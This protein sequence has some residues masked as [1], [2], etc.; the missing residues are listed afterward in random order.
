MPVRPSKLWLVLGI[1]LAM[2]PVWGFLGTLFGMMSSFQQVAASSAPPT[3]KGVAEGIAISQ[4]STFIG[5]AIAPVGAL[6]I[7][8]YVIRS[9]RSTNAMH[10][11]ENEELYSE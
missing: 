6:L 1:I 5:L 3:P 7:A 4:Y 8:W 2:G 10:A 9:S 11:D